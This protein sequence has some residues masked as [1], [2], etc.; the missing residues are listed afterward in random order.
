MVNI[1]SIKRLAMLVIP[2]ILL[3]LV[4]TFDVIRATVEFDNASITILREFFVLGSFTLIGLFIE[5]RRAMSQRNA[6][7]EIGRVFFAVVISL[8]IS[9]IV[10]F[11]QPHQLSEGGSFRIHQSAL[12]LLAS[13]LIALVLGVLSLYLLVIIHDLVLFKRRKTTW[14]NYFIYLF[15]LFAACAADFPF[16]LPEGNI[17]ASI[18]FSLTMMFIVVNSF[19]QNWIMYL[20]RREKKYSIVYSIL[21][22][23]ALVLLDIYLVSGS[24]NN[25]AIISYSRP[26]HTFIRL[27]AFFGTV[28]FG[29][30]FISTLFHLPTAEVFERKQSELIS[31]HNLSRLVTQVFDFNDLLNTVTQMTSEVCG[32]RSVWL[33]LFSLNDNTG[34]MSV[35]VVA[36]RNIT[37]QE[38]DLIATD[39]GTQL[40]RY[41]MDSHKALLIEDIWADRR[42]KHLKAKGFARGSLLTVPLLSHGKLI[43]VLHATKDFQN[44][45]DQ[46]DIDV[47]TTFADHVSIAIENSRLISKSIERERLHQEMMVAQRMQKRLLPQSLPN[48]SSAE[49]AAVSESSLEV[50]GDYYDIITLPD[51]RIG[52]V[53]GDVSGKG[54]SAAFYM[55]EVKG[56]VMSLSK[57]CATPRE[58]LSCA[59]DTL[60]ET[61]E[62]NMFISAIYGVLDV[63]NATLTLARAGHCPVIYISHNSVELIRSTGIGLGLTGREQFDH[64][65]EERTMKLQPGDICIFYTDGITE[66]RNAE[67]E[68]YGY[69]RLM[70]IASTCTDCSANEM[71]EMILQSVRTF[72]GQG[73]YNDDVTL[74]VLKWLGNS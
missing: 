40:Q 41:L 34:E 37:Q 52:I 5:K 9:A 46:D 59:N 31:L 35:E 70:Q 61:L 38:I 63:R 65:T 54:V 11:I 1:S 72:I 14:R 39:D 42:T 50:G 56:I 7:R 73:T 17:V 20:S 33:E 2:A 26:L 8:I 43:G 15:L 6:P 57:I 13:T 67:M 66:S 3:P 44:A 27:N 51:K 21:L 36:K 55:A 74:I 24:D 18:F 25:N 22:F 71:K 45:F 10:S 60:M 30:T 47:M 32:A 49:F 48:L 28:Y 4:F 64:A 68:E 12:V 19:K 62:K 58:L 53:V 29:V 16:L 69:E 23:T